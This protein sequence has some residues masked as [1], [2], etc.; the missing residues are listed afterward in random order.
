MVLTPVER[1]AQMNK[2]K[3][4]TKSPENQRVV[5]LID[6]IGIE[7][8]GI[9]SSQSWYDDPRGLLFTLARYKFVAKML[10]GK[11]N[12]L[13]V[14]CGDAFHSRLVQQEVEKL[15]V[16]DHDPLFIEDIKRRSPAKWKPVAFVHNMYDG[17]TKETYDAIYLLDVLEHIDKES[18]HRF[19]GHI[20]DSLEDEGML[21]I[22]MPSLESQQHASEISRQGHVN[23]KSGD[24]LRA[25]LQ[26]LCSQLMV[27]SMND[28]V[29][30]TGFFPM[31]HYLIAV[32]CI[33][34]QD[35]N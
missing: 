24:E 35:G 2:G 17:P 14:G 4:L 27:F 10:R 31:A 9:M 20:L 18:E 1:T 32:A 26:P 11:R 29:V 33:K 12:V 28:E 30:H 34:K 8:L 23:C 15:S 5:D 16:T 19:I 25:L 13:E 6:E 21:I 3:K 7:T 22:G